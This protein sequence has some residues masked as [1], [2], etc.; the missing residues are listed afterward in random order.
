MKLST[1]CS[2]PKY[3]SRRPG[4]LRCPLFALFAAAGLSGCGDDTPPARCESIHGTQQAALSQ[5]DCKSPVGICTAGTLTGTGFLDGTTVMATQKLASSAGLG[6]AEEMTT[7]SYTGLLSITAPAG[8]LSLR[9]TGLFDTG[10]PGGLFVS[11]D[12]I[13]SGT[14]SLADRT[15]Y[16]F[17]EGSGSTR[18]TNA[19]SGEVCLPG[20]APAAAATARRE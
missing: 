5:A 7:L 3:P 18:F 15:G 8:T 9:E 10:Y 16:L 6:T 20:S 17:F 4:A 12:I 1:A 14:G 2:I 11:R 13:L 19:V